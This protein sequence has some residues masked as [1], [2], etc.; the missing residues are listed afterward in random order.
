MTHD[1][2]V[3]TYTIHHQISTGVTVNLVVVGKLAQLKM[4]ASGHCWIPRGGFDPLLDI[5]A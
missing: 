2:A 4:L 3:L 1:L 5:K